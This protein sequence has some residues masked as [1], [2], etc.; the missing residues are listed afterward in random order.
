MRSRSSGT[1][2]AARR[3]GCES[4]REDVAQS[5]GVGFDNLEGF[6]VSWRCRA[7]PRARTID[8]RIRI[9]TTA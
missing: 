4:V 6:A 1:R 2:L 8:G 3:P 9:A 5:E 7:S